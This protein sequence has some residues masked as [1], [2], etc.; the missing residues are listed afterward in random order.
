MVLNVSSWFS[1]IGVQ[2]N[3]KIK[4]IEFPLLTNYYLQKSFINIANTYYAAMQ[5]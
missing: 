1:Q 3:N 2:L 5:H 4:I